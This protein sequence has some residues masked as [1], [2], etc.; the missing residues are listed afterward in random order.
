MHATRYDTIRV[1]VEPERVMIFAGSSQ[2]TLHTTFPF[3]SGS[4]FEYLLWLYCPGDQRRYD[5][6]WI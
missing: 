4:G 1:E 5:P 2:D 3:N 6:G